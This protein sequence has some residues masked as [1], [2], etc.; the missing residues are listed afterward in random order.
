MFRNCRQLTI[1][2]KFLGMCNFEQTQQAHYVFDAPANVIVVVVVRP[3]LY[4]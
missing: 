3:C 2:T 1:Y 4:L